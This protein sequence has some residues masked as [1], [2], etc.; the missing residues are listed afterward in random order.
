M[1]NG[2]IEITGVEE[3][4]N[5]TDP[6]QIQ[7]TLSQ[8]PI[9]QKK[10]KEVGQRCKDGLSGKYLP[11]VG[12]AATAR[13]IV[14]LADAL[15]GPGAPVNYYGISGGTVIGAWLVNSQYHSLPLPQ[16]QALNFS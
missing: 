6:V 8:A 5:F 7:A 13:D 1:F 4:G 10:Y 3:T 11:Y 14:A 16:I 2:T 15:D 9:L 12:N